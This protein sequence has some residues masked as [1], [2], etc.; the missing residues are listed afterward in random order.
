M[1]KKKELVLVQTR[2]PA[3]LAKKLK[4]DA[5]ERGMISQAALIRQI[6]TDHYA[7]EE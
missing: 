4:A 6:I 1:A 5:E 7:E 2:I 3:D